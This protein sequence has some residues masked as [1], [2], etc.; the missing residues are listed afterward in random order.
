MTARVT[1]EEFVRRLED[2]CIG[3]SRELPRRRR[4]LHIIL[5]S[6]SSWARPGETFTHDYVQDRLEH[7][8]AE[9]CPSLSTDHVTLR[10]TLVDYGYLDRDDS[11]RSY[12][13]GTGYPEFQM[14]PGVAYIDPAEVA[15][16]ALAAR[17]E[18]KRRHGE[19]KP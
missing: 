6:A 14:E 9:A 7:W 18:R 19:S 12:C 3:G 17:A 16:E 4:D 11:G 5:T 15:R 1:V 13:L 10:R 8:L 2:I